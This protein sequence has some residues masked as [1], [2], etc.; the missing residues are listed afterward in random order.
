[1]TIDSRGL[2]CHFRE[3]LS[4][5]LWHSGSV[6]L[7]AE[8]QL[9]HWNGIQADEMAWHGGA[10]SLESII[11]NCTTGVTNGGNAIAMAYGGHQFGSWVPRLGDG[12]GLLLGEWPGQDGDLCGDLW[13]LHLKGAGPSHYSRGFDG[14]A[15]LRSTIREY[16]AS[17]YLNAIGVPSTS[18]LA[19]WA[20]K[21]PVERELGPEPRAMLAR[22]CKT[23]IRFGHFE[24]LS[25]SGKH[26]HL[27]DL[28]QYCSDRYWPENSDLSI[29]QQ[30]LQLLQKTCEATARMIGYWQCYGFCHG[31][32]NTDNMSIIGD[33]FDFGP[34]SFLDTY[35]PGFICN[36]TDVNGRYAFNSQ[37]QAGQWNCS[38]LATALIPVLLNAGYTE[39]QATDS[40]SSALATY[41]PQFVETCL[42][43]MSRRLGVQ[44]IELSEVQEIWRLL[45][46]QSLDYNYFF[47]NWQACMSGNTEDIDTAYQSI[48][49]SSDIYKSLLEKQQPATGSDNFNPKFI[50]RNAW[51]Q[52]VIASAYKGDYTP[53]NDMVACASSPFDEV[54][55]CWREPPPVAHRGIRLSC[56]S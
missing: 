39:K 2:S 26:Q 31:V 8:S 56:S 18:A 44:S 22:V 40:L 17:V 21:E 13:D 16:L 50:L 34:Y 11:R 38:A 47:G 42:Q 41:E 28:I 45:A 4:S 9:L 35:E 12:R 32:M 51:M 27:Q 49:E 6:D 29:D 1:M 36:K 43:V 3:H 52:Q 23:H 5:D 15:V 25:H 37:P 10:E 7:N 46:E 30:A 48:I 53:F 55:A 24:Y 19:I 14:R 54:A 20:V 33:T